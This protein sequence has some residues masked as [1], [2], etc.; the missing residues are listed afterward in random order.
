MGVLGFTCFTA[1]AKFLTSF[2]TITISIVTWYRLY[3]FF[4]F[5]FG[6]TLS[7]LSSFNRELKQRRSTHVNR[8]KDLYLFFNMS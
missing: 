7:L 6:T 3:I 1:D 2:R 5:N 8:K 4:L